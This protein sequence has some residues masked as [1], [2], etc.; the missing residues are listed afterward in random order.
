ML[1]KVT[2]FAI[3]HG[4][5][6]H[7][8]SFSVEFQLSCEDPAPRTSLVMPKHKPKHLIILMAKTLR[9]QLSGNS[10]KLSTKITEGKERWVN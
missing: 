6:L 3:A 8:T 9:R 7:F 1:R 4:K 2:H 10:G 5:C